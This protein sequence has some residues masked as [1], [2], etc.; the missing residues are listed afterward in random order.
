[1]PSMV[2]EMGTESRAKQI[3]MGLLVEGWEG[4]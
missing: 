1:M 4:A 2:L 3:L